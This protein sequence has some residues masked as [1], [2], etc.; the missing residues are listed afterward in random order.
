MAD[1]NRK[2]P[3]GIQTAARYSHLGITFAAV[4]LAGV[5]GGKYLDSKWNTSPYLTLI[6]AFLGGAAGF[7]YIIK[8]M[9]QIQQNSEDSDH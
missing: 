2:V 1:N 6:G 3:K 9:T 7:Y 4:I 5:F 8:E